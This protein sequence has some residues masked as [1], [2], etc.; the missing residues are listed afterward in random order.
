MFYVAKCVQLMLMLSW[1]VNISKCFVMFARLPNSWKL[2]V[3]FSFF[4]FFRIQCIEMLH[5]YQRVEFIHETQTGLFFQ[6]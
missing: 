2:D 6:F 3:F 1:L 4:L 5:V